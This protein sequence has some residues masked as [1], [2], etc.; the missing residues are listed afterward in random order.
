MTF[1]SPGGGYSRAH[2]TEGDKLIYIWTVSSDDASVMSVRE[3]ERIECDDA[4]QLSE[5]LIERRRVNAE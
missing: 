2:L 4:R 5:A 1:S 3:M